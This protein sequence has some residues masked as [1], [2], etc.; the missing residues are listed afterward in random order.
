MATTEKTEGEYSSAKK[1]A[2]EIIKGQ[3]AEIEQMNQLL[4]K[5]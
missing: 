5:N 2:D 1:L 4:G 3:T